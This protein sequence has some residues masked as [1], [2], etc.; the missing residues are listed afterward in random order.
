MVDVSIIVPVYNDLH[1]I[2]LTLKAL[3]AQSV[4]TEIYEII[5]IDN[6]STDGTIEWLSTQKGIT[7]LKELEHKG[8][9]YSCR[10]RGIEMAKGKIIVLLDSTCIPAT[11]WIESGVDFFEKTH[12]KLFGGRVKFHDSDQPSSWR[13]FDSVTHVQMEESIKLRKEAKTANLWVKIDLFERFGKFREGVRSGE[14]VR[15]TSSCTQAEVELYYAEECIVRKFSRGMSELLSKQYRI[16]KGQ[17]TRW[18]G[19]GIV[20]KKMVSSCRALVPA[21]PPKMKA[22]I[23][24]NEDYTSSTRIILDMYLITFTARFVT[25]C[26]N[27]VGLLKMKDSSANKV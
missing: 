18:Q 15:W 19:Q 21:S 1:A 2:K 12:C 27:L 20:F 24:R 8:S 25:I 5:I 22:L 14:D 23:A 3:L 6:G 13:L 4:S 11:N 17:V 7:L 26:G 10:N 16:G 9:P